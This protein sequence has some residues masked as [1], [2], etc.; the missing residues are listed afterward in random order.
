MKYKIIDFHTHPFEEKLNNICNYKNFLDMSA[1]KTERDLQS[2]G[3][4]KICGSVIGRLKKDA[5]YSFDDVRAINDK[6]LA[7]RE[8]YGDFYYP[9]FHIHPSFVRESV[10]EIERFNKLGFKLVGELVPYIQDWSDGFDSKPF[11]EILEAAEAY[12]M[13]VDFHSSGSE[14]TEDEI[15]K[16]VS[17]FK[18]LKIVAA[19]PGE[20]DAFMRHL[21][22]MEISDNYYL[23]L[24]GTGIFRHGLLRYGIDSFGAERFIFGSDYPT[25]NPAAFVGAVADDFLLTEEE[26]LRIFYKNAVALLNL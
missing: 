4:V 14:K 8:K 17:R 2:L 18:N 22:R 25:C 3:I 16:M 6:A 11:F 9:G 19:H 20:Y 10:A 26:K 1:E 7:L 12:G 5:G 13:V 15:D 24:S 23:D 21:K